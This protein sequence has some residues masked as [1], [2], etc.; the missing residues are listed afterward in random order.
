VPKKYAAQFSEVWNSVYAANLKSGMSKAD[1]EA[2]AFTQS[3]GVINKQK[4]KDARDVSSDGPGFSAPADKASEDGGQVSDPQM[5]LRGSE[6]QPRDPDGKF[7]SGSQSSPHKDAHV[8][9]AANKAKREAEKQHG[10][11]IGDK[12]SSIAGTAAKV[13]SVDGDV[14][15]VLPEGKTETELWHA[16]HTTAGRSSQSVVIVVDSAIEYRWGW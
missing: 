14:L 10:I 11:K 6:D 1:A 15:K 5:S 13:I 7:A 8:Q 12:V 3:H 9:Q 2:N 4:A 16:D